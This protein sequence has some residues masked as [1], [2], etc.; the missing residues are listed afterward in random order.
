[1]PKRK[2]TE[3]VAKPKAKGTI[4]D[5]EKII[6]DSN[7]VPA[8]NMTDADRNRGEG[9]QADVVERPASFLSVTMICP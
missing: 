4:I 5:F 3:T 6:T 9:G 1:M 8:N 2:R 7:I